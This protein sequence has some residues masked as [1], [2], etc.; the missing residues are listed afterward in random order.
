[1]SAYNLPGPFF[2][3]APM[4]D[5]T[6]TVFRQVVAGCARPDLFFTE[7]VNAD[8]LQSPGRPHLLKKLQH[9]DSEK[10]LIAQIWGLN[11]DNFYKTAEQIANG[12]F[13]DFAGIDLKATPMK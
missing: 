10:P 12:E 5:V 11:P 7:F 6:D 4:D 13:G 8:G 3:L 9:T 1:M 2:I